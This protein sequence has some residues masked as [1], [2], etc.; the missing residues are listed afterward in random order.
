LSEG[1]T[2]ANGGLFLLGLLDTA[3]FQLVRQFAL[4]QA[5]IVEV[6]A[7]VQHAEHLPFLCWT[8]IEA[9]LKGLQA[10]PPTYTFSVRR[11]INIAIIVAQTRSLASVAS[12][13]SQERLHPQPL[14]R[15]GFLAG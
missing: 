13:S 9:I 14:K 12:G 10:H 11:R 5:H 15:C 8:G 3:T 6:A 4:F 7:D 2:I 1:L